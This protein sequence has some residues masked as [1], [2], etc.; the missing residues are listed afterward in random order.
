ML[1]HLG[2]VV[3]IGFLLASAIMNYLFGH[4]LGRTPL[5]ASVYGGVGVLAVIANALCPF[6]AQ[7]ACKTK[8][9]PTMYAILFF[10]LLCLIYSLT[11]ALGF[12]AE[13]RQSLTAPKAALHEIMQS[14]LKTLADLEDRKRTPQI[15]TRIHALRDE[16]N[17]LRAA[18]AA[19]DPDPQTALLAKIM[20][21]DRH[22]T[23]LVL[24]ILFALMVEAGA[25]IG[26]FAAL[27]TA[28]PQRPVK[29]KTEKPNGKT[30]IWNPT[31]KMGA[32][33]R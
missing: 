33:E 13:N 10:W 8:R 22:D 3:A 23:K 18:G 30:K 26:L 20:R 9:F 24:V 25:A 28:A 32:T 21:L 27:S 7:S 17:S 5:E 6:F 15:E 11:S 16:I 29:V 14:K 19:G 12:A 2:T 4:A 31:Y 1:A